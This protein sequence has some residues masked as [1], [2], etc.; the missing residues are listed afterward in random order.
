MDRVNLKKNKTVLVAYQN[1]SLQKEA[2]QLVKSLWEKD[3]SAYI[4]YNSKNLKKQFKKG[5][6]IGAG[7]TFILGE[8]EMKSN[9][10]SVKN[11]ETQEQISITKGELFQWLEKNI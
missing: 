11:M 1:Q 10:I 3:Y 4:E 6:R 2:I 9:T 7:F 8:D 5:D